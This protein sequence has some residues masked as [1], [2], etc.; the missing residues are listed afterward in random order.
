MTASRFDTMSTQEIFAQAALLVEA[1]TFER[2]CLWKVF[3][4]KEKWQQIQM[5]NGFTIGQ[6]DGRPI[7]VSIWYAY[8]HDKLVVFW[9][10]TSQVVDY[11]AVDAWLEKSLA[12]AH[13][14]P[15]S[16]P[17]TDALNAGGYFARLASS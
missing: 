10:A 13:V 5:G 4:N 3:A 12:V 14:D 8:V 1:N 16:V 9:E 15:N 7:C 6:L 17:R 2:L 11:V